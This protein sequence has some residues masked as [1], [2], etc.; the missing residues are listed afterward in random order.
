MMRIELQEAFPGSNGGRGGWHWRLVIN[1]GGLEQVLAKG[2]A[3]TADG[4]LY[5]VVMEARLYRK[6][7]FHNHNEHNLSAAEITG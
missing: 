5:A 1:R 2:F 6:D 4:A 3:E 7:I